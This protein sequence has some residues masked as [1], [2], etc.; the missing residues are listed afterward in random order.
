VLAPWAKLQ[1]ML[2]GVLFL[3]PC[4]W[5]SFLGVLLLGVLVPGVRVLGVA[6]QGVASPGCCYYVIV[7]LEVLD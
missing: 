6:S 5:P 2:Q 1:A 4:S 7:V 3:D